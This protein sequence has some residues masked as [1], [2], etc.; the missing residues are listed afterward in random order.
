MRLPSRIF[1]DMTLRLEEMDP[2]ENVLRVPFVTATEGFQAITEN[3]GSIFC[4]H[5]QGRT[6]HAIERI[7][8]AIARGAGPGKL[9]QE[10]RFQC[11]GTA[12]HGLLAHGQE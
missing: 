5:E 9:E 7:Q 2:R 8:E 1:E 4:R 3:A 11:A 10:G 12:E 6:A